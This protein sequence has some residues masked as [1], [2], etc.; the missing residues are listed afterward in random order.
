MAKTLHFTLPP[1][2]LPAVYGAALKQ[3]TS[4]APDHGYQL[5]VANRLWGRQGH[6][7][8]DGF[9]KN[10][11]DEFGA[12]LGQLDFHG[13]ADTARQTI[14]DWVAKQTADKIKSL[15][16]A[17][18]L[19]PDTKLVLTNAIY[20]KAD[21]QQPFKTESTHKTPFHLSADKSADVDLMAQTSHFRHAQADGVALLEMPY[22]SGDLSMVVLLPD[23]VDGLAELEK[24]LTL[25]NY[26]TWLAKLKA[27]TVSVFLP[28]FVETSDT[29]ALR[30]S[31]SKLGMSLPFEDA[32]DFSGMDGERD[33]RIS[34]ALHKAFVA[35]DETGTTAAAATAIPM[36][37][38]AIRQPEPPI[39]FRADHPFVFL[40]RDTRSGSILFIGRFMGPK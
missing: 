34:D 2:Q 7:F 25:D 14:N 26:T 28:K 37:P 22:K 24:S 16:P 29:I 30:E 12:E 21:W 20:F 4:A 38:T 15:I 40:I 9:L 31:L 17:G 3:L 6:S 18:A 27:K 32:A 11:R 23:K 8:L 39:E 35:V 19:A 1:E 36:R 13:A 10:N 5:H 33:L